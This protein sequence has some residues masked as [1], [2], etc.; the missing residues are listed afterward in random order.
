VLG[1]GYGT[2]EQQDLKTTTATDSSI[3]TAG[4]TLFYLVTVKNRL[5]EEG[6]KGS[7]SDGTERLGATDLPVC[8]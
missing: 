7:R 4:N 3:P 6:T 1:D 5:Q 2:C 8:P